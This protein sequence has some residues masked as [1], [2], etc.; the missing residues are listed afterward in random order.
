[1]KLSEKRRQRLSQRAKRKEKE[2]N[3]KENQEEGPWRLRNKEQAQKTRKTGF[4]QNRR[5]LQE[6]ERLRENG[7]KKKN[8]SEANRK[9]NSLR[10][11]S[12]ERKQEKIWRQ[13]AWKGSGAQGER[14]EAN[15]SVRKG[16]KRHVDSGG[17]NITTCDSNRIYE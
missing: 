17:C 10:E 11:R 9:K 4:R 13:R 12:G 5:A 14:P 15:P 6:R 16:E 3:L 1:M 2:P 8:L 7:E